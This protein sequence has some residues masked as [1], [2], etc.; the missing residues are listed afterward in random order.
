V[1][2]KDL[3]ESTESTDANRAALRRYVTETGPLAAPF[4]TEDELAQVHTINIYRNRYRNRDRDRD[5]YRYRSIQ[6]PY[7]HA[8]T[9][10][11]CRQY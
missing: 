1:A 7:T 9:P 5:R 10:H 11:T 8:A 6:H 2:V 4:I 3:L